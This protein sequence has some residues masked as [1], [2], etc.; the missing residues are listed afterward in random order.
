MYSLPENISKKLGA[1]SLEI[2]I[3]GRNLLLW[4]KEIKFVDPDSR[5][6]ELS[7]A[8]YRNLAST[9]KLYFNL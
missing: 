4:T 6:D 9:L 5:V 3:V 7:S 1:S 2:G 8:S